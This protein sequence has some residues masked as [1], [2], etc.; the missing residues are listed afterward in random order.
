M[1]KIVPIPLEGKNVLLRPPS[2]NDLDGLSQAAH[3]GEIWNNPY[4][5]FP[6]MNE[7]SI[8]LQELLK[9]SNSSLPFIIIHKP[10]NII[11]GSTRYFNIDHENHRLEIGHTWIAKSYRRTLI[12]TETKFLM[13]QY[14]FEHIKC[15]AVE[16]RTDALNTISKKAIERIGAKED[17]VLRYHKIMRGDRIRNTV[18]YSIIQPEWPVVKDNLLQKMINYDN[19]YSKT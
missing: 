6:S 3:D 2:I 7:I 14:A 15:I 5:F 8:Y 13:L 9:T 19:I 4:A 10:S 1:L 17:G 18:C 11:V 12:N 16:I